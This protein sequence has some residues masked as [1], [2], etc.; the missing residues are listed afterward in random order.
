[1]P[2]KINTYADYEKAIK[3]RYA[4]IKSSG[5]ADVL[6]LEPTPSGLKRYCLLLLPDLDNRDLIAYKRFFS[7]KEGV[8]IYRQIDNFDT[9]KFKALR[10][11]LNGD[12]ETTAIERLELLAILV[13]LQPRPY[14]KFSKANYTKENDSNLNEHNTETVY[15]EEKI[16]EK[17]KQENTNPNSQAILPAVKDTEESFIPQKFFVVSKSS[18]KANYIK[19]ILLILLIAIGIYFLKD[20]T[21]KGCMIWNNDHYEKVS[22]DLEVN[23]YAGNKVI[24]L[25]E[26]LVRYQKKIKITDTTTFFNADGSHR[27]WYGKSADKKYEY[28]AYPGNHPET[29]VEL[30]KITH[31]MI[32]NNI[33]N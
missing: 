7:L 28:F 14:N 1:M 21:Q 11:F 23:R 27:V 2:M 32:D 18:N 19:L 8:D 30:R 9:S 5:E 3:A 15:K 10:N 16:N 33:N 26:K 4:E 25:D 29:G 6:L 17:S 31:Y 22:C 12:S 20:D 13:G 24:P